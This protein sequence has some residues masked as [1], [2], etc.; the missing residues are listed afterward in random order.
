M[1]RIL[2]VIL[3]A[4]LAFVAALVVTVFLLWPSAPQ[5]K[6]VLA[7]SP[8]LKVA[9]RTSVVIAPA[10]IALSAIR[11]AMGARARRDLSGKRDNPVGQILQSAELGWTI[12]RGPLALTGRAEGLAIVA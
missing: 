12:S 9:T 6:P 4:A 1:R 8:P 3:V 7:D 5:K 2:P 11:D 10:A